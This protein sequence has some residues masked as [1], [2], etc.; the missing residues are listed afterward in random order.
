MCFHKWG[1][2][3]EKGRGK[4]VYHYVFSGGTSNG[5]YIKQERYCLKCNKVQMKTIEN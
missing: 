5:I 2:W 1:K 3:K 4:M